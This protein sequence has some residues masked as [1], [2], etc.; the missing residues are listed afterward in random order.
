M[1]S[2]VSLNKEEVILLSDH[3]G[4]HD[5]L[6]SDGR[7]FAVTWVHASLVCG[8]YTAF[9]AIISAASI[10]T[11]SLKSPISG[12]RTPRASHTPDRL[13][14]GL[15][16]GHGDDAAKEGVSIDI[17]DALMSGDVAA[18]KE[19]VNAGGDCSVRDSIGES[20]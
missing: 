16:A 17:F 3:E 18:V 14:A 5:R 1:E 7:N 9:S 2:A 8:I 6:A 4:A 19:Y 13:R 10:A 11:A 12:G 20:V 15:R